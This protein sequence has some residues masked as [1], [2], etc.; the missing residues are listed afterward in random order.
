[1]RIT[2]LSISNFKAI[3]EVDLSGLADMVVIAGPNGCGKS[4]IFDAIR[5]LKSAYGGYQPNE[6]QSWF[7]EFQINVNQS[8]DQ[9]STLLQV[10]DRQMKL[11]A[12]FILAAEEIQYLRDH[13]SQILLDQIWREEVPELAGWRIMTGLPLAAN[14]RTHEPRVLD[15]LNRELPPFLRE[16]DVESHPA[17]VTFE[18]GKSAAVEPSRILEVLFTTYDPGKLGVIDY[19]SSSRNYAREQVGGINLNI[20]A[21]S[22][23]L[24]QQALYNSAAKYNNL[25]SQMASAYVRQLLAREA[26]SDAGGND[27]VK[28][29]KE[30]FSTFFPGKEFLGP[31]PMSDGRMTFPVRTASGSAHDID[32][33]SSGEKEILYG[34]LRLWNSEPRNSILL[35]DEPELHLNPR[36]IRGLA[37]F[38]H[39]H[40]GKALGNQLW[41]VTHSDTLIR[42]AVGQAGFRVFHLQAPGTFPTGKQ[43]TPIEVARDFDRAVIDI[44]GDLAAYRP[45]A[46]VVLLEGGG[47]TDFDVRMT[48]LLFPNFQERVNPLSGGSKRRVAELYRLLDEA[49]QKGVVQDRFFAI[50]DRDNDGASAVGVAMVYT[51]DRYHIENYLLDPECITA[52]LK[53]LNRL[54]SDLDDLSKMESALIA[55]AREVIPSLVGHELRTYAY[56]ELSSQIDLGFDPKRTDVGTAM[57][58]AVARSAT[59]LDT[60]ATINLTQV[61]LEKMERKVRARAEIALTDGTWRAE[62]PG[63]AILARFAGHHGDGVSYETLRDLILARMRDLAR[64][65]PGMAKVINAILDS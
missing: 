56:R 51:W 49:S 46:K 45:G 9:W 38:Y 8:K 20:E 48:C 65:P 41:L 17:E 32:D 58:E 31:Q 7:G 6:W 64:Q 26:G 52:A 61:A 59:C 25:K 57:A 47:D 1:M 63:R 19:H 18:V 35:I 15:R 27:L 13:A 24:R 54:T 60:S 43:A 42:E 55:C 33:L 62:F 40:I 29:L 22:D 11:A 39:R 44:V 37:S 12:Q 2:H 10:K 28:T 36:L 30:L 5:L 50:T 3:T 14:V 34:Y 23:R 21:D 4:C 53:D 16:L